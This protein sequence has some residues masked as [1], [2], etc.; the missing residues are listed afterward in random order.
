MAVDRRDR[1][2]D[3]RCDLTGGDTLIR[4][5]SNQIS[6]LQRQTATALFPLLREWIGRRGIEHGL[7][8]RLQST[9]SREDVA[10]RFVRVALDKALGTEW[11]PVGVEH[12]TP[13]FP[14]RSPCFG[15]GFARSS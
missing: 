11:R 12:F 13:D 2:F 8:L 9:E 4:E 15:M 3:L 6:L 1:A 14:D 7:E 5:P 10:K